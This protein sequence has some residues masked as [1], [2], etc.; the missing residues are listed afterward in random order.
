MLSYPTEAQKGVFISIFW[1]I[2]NLGAV[3]G[4]SVSFG[5]NFHSMVRSHQLYLASRLIRL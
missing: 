1:G 3:V 5:Q 2:F 4:S